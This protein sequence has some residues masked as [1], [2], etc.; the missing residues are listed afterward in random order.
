MT[1]YAAGLR[2]SEVA[3]LRVSDID[4]ARMTTSFDNLVECARFPTPQTQRRY[5]QE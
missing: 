3:R 5:G 4:S 1:I 2:R